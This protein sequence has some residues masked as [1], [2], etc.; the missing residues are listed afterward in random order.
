[1]GVN[2]DLELTKS[3]IYCV[4][5]VLNDAKKSENLS[6]KALGHLYALRSDFFYQQATQSKQ[7]IKFMLDDLNKAHSDAQTALMLYKGCIALD[8][9]NKLN[10]AV[11]K[12]IYDAELKLKNIKKTMETHQKK[13]HSPVAE[14]TQEELN[15][16]RHSK[17]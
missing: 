6:L 1:M 16:P 14:V 2:Y 3:L 9:H 11:T 17:R 7:K 15:T 4:N 12:D 8:N 13:S 10:K 5:M